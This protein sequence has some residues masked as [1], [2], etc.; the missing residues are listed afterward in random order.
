MKNRIGLL[1]KRSRLLCA[2]GLIAGIVLLMSACGETIDEGP[3]FLELRNIPLH[4]GGMWADVE[5]FAT[6]DTGFSNPIVTFQRQQIANP[7]LDSQGL[8]QHNSIRIPAQIPDEHRS[9]T[10]N[11]RLRVFDAHNSA[12]GAYRLEGVSRRT[13][14]SGT[15]V[16]GWS[17]ITRTNPIS[18]SITNIPPSVPANMNTGTV[19]STLQLSNAPAHIAIFRSGGFASQE[20]PIALS[21]VFRMT[22][23]TGNIVNMLDNSPSV[24]VAPYNDNA[25]MDALRVFPSP[26]LRLS[27]RF[28]LSGTYEI[29]VLIAAETGIAGWRALMQGRNVNLGSNNMNFQTAFS[30]MGSIPMAVPTALSLDDDF[31]HG[32]YLAQ[33]FRE[34]VLRYLEEHGE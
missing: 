9:A 18:L 12:S 21:G 26:H 1:W 13:I 32:A 2:A 34:M 11:V 20:L 16:V 10:V 23:G 24:G 14:R 17:D 7:G 25:I 31:D 22:P 3:A 4:L 5:L 6:A 29:Y 30:F 33:R 28:A 19:G 27:E 8:I 15:N